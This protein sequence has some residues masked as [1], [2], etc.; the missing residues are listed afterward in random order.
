MPD[1][2]GN[3]VGRFFVYFIGSILL[4]ASIAGC[5]G[6]QGRPPVGP[7]PPGAQARLTK[8]DKSLGAVKR[9][10]AA[11][12]AE[13][14]SADAK[15]DKLRSKPY[16]SGFERILIKYP[17]LTDPGKQAQITPEVRARLSRWSREAKVPWQAM[18]RD[19]YQ[20][21]DRCAILDMKRVAVRQMLISVQA[22][23]MAVVMMEAGAGHMKKA[24]KIFALVNSLD[25]PG[26]KLDSIRLNR[27]GLYGGAAD[28][29]A[30]L[31]GTKQ[32]SSNPAAN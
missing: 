26:A 27:L 3:T 25:K 2:P 22:A 31:G 11:F 5:A 12:F 14:D 19:Y 13:L 6:M 15:I 30:P 7:P 20:L 32:K 1:R 10:E 23:Y 28:D 4:I 29:A 17:S 18:M 16:W 8:A 21:V 9:Q 24:N